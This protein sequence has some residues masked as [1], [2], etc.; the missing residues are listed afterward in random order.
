MPPYQ[1]NLATIRRQVVQKLR[2]DPELD[3]ADADVWINLAYADVVQRTEVCQKTRC[4]PLTEDV[5]SYAIPPGVL[6]IKRLDLIY[7]DRTVSRP[8]QEVTLE[9]LLS[10]R[11]TESQIPVLCY[12]PVYALMGHSQIEIWPIPGPDQILRFWYV[13]SPEALVADTDV[14]VFPEPFGSK[15]LEFGGCVEG[16]RFKKDPLL[17]DYE[18][19]FE[20]WIGRFTSM[21]NR[22]NLVKQF[23]I[24]ERGVNAPH[25]PSADYAFN[26]R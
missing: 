13:Y 24:Y 16:G 3:G 11:H 5:D 18:Q 6:I 22:S 2:L 26:W 10:I 21:L 8:M 12:D 4:S 20:Y 25:D 23:P 1:G 9:T 7:Q 15:L 14:P 19:A 17:S